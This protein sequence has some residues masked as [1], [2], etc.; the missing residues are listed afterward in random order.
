MSA[1]RF[2]FLTP[3]ERLTLRKVRFVV[4]G[5]VA[6]VL[7]G[8]NVITGDL[9]I[10]YARDEQNLERMALVLKELGA[11]LRGAPKDIP[12]I[13][14]AKTLRKGDSFTFDTEL[15]PIDILGTPSGMLGGY[16][17][18]ERGAEEL[19]LD[20]VTVKVASLDDLIRMKRSAG[21]PKD[22]L[23]VEELGALR[24]EI[25]AQAAEER[26]KRRKR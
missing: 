17:E 4:I 14:D 18:L 21:R 22:L 25:D 24:D 11:T 6:A 7:H 23:M 13:L 1:Q 26:K 5:G 12:F 19:E 15:G 3:L 9:D 16:E 2:D 10:C 20:G 8:S